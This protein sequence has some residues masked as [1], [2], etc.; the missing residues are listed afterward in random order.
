MKKRPIKM[1]FKAFVFFL[2]M[3]A[4]P[5]SAGAVSTHNY[6]CADFS[7]FDGT[8]TGSCASD[9]VSLSGTG[10]AYDYGPPAFP[11]PVSSTWY[12]SLVYTGTGTGQ[13]TLICPSTDG[14]TVNLTGDLSDATIVA[15]TGGDCGLRLRANSSFSGDL[16]SICITDTLGGCGGGPS[17]TPTTT[18]A[19]SSPDQIQQNLFFGWAIFYGSMFFVVWIFKRR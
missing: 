9:I 13:A 17:P 4:A 19:T 16:S 1:R 5:M 7:M 11:I 6:T 15:G 12:L 18:V 14:P 2:L 10:G 8:P 3:V